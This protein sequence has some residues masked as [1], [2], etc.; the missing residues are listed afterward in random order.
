MT[1]KLKLQS[2]AVFAKLDADGSGGEGLRIG[3]GVRGLRMGVGV[4]VRAYECSTGEGGET[5]HFQP[6][7]WPC[8]RHANIIVHSL[9]QWS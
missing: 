4:G 2:E 9:M 7:L 8:C 1:A 6:S 5:G 3:V